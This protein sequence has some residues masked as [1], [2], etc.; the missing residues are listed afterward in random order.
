MSYSLLKGTHQ[1]SLWEI[2]GLKGTLG[3]YF[4]FYGGIAKSV[5][6][7]YD[8]TIS[9]V[10]LTASLTKGREATEPASEPA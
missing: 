7:I 3:S 8:G 4:E 5:Y 9:I 6:K 10:S 2:E 1:L